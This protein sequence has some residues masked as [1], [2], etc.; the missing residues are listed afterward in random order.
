MIDR[1]EL[2]YWVWKLIRNANFGGDSGD[3]GDG[4]GGDAGG[5]G[6]DGS[7]G[8]AGGD[9]GAPSGDAGAPSG[10]AGGDAGFGAGATDMS[11]ATAGITGAAA[12]GD[13]GQSG[14]GFSGPGGGGFG[15]SGG[16]G[17]PSGTGDV[18]DQGS[19]AATAGMGV[20]GAAA[21]GAGGFGGGAGGGPGG[22]ASLSEAMSGAPSAFGNDSLTGGVGG[23]DPG[24][25]GDPAGTGP[26]TGS[27]GSP[28]AIVGGEFDAL[29]AGAPASN[30]GFSSLSVADVAPSLAPTGL[31]SSLSA[32]PGE[33]IAAAGQGKG[34]IDD[35]ASTAP[36]GASSVL[37]PGVAP[38]DQQL[39]Q[40]FPG[41]TGGGNID[42]S[43]GLTGPGVGV[44]GDLNAGNVGAGAGGILD[45][46]GGAGGDVGGSTAVS[47]LGLYG[48]SGQPGGIELTGGTVV[49]AVSSLQS[50]GIVNPSSQ[51]VQNFVAAAQ[52]LQAQLSAAGLDP[53][54]PQIA[55]LIAQLAAQQ[56]TARVAA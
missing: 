21:G 52:S 56:A 35:G 51:D 10:G 6:G 13:E 14:A 26:F 30:P 46:G 22:D 5:G 23:A 24:A 43:G 2:P 44:T 1:Y 3:A 28:A 40:N 31:G 12:T 11:G 42:L 33:A 19:Q 16:T 20:T 8:D 55:A 15:G 45:T 48:L 53:S 7:G 17:A 4:A 9:T 34:A 36:V 27:F 32:M 25:F 41:F 50:A 47:P 29:A 54:N 18:G 39:S 38:T 37:S 49:Q